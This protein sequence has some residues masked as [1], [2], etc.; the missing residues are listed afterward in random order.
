M[1][2]QPISGSVDLAAVAAL[3]VVQGT[4]AGTAAVQ[5]ALDQTAGG[6]AAPVISSSVTA[7][8][9]LELFA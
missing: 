7:P 3:A 2:A 9:S 4:Q 8:G 1:S 5:A 6:S